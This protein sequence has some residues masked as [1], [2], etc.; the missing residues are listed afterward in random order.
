MG[1]IAIYSPHKKILGERNLRKDGIRMPIRFAEYREGNLEP[2]SY[3]FT[4][5]G[6]LFDEYMRIKALY[7]GRVAEWTDV[8]HPECDSTKA[9]Y[10]PSFSAAA[11]MY[12]S[13]HRR[14]DKQNDRVGFLKNH[15]DPTPSLDTHMERFLDGLNIASTDPD[16]VNG[17][18]PTH[19]AESSETPT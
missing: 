1:D 8:W 6:N 19:A 12:K 14:E 5:R 3:E 13:R 4:T 9:P 7:H 2:W 17:E 18:L 11:A 16:E 15:N 10:L